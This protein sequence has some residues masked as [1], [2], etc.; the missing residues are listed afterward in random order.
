LDDGAVGLYLRS[1]LVGVEDLRE[2]GG[3]D[4]GVEVDVESVEE[5]TEPS[6]YEVKRKWSK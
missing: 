3:G 1:T 5:P 2:E 4:D 6:T